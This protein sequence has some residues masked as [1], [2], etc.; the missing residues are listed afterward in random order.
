MV[1]LNKKQKNNRQFL[2]LSRE[3]Y[4]FKKILVID[5]EE[6]LKNRIINDLTKICIKNGNLLFSKT[7]ILELLTNSTSNK[8][9]YTVS[10]N[11]LNICKIKG[12]KTIIKFQ[13]FLEY[14]IVPNIIDTI[15]A[16]NL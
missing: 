7:E 15:K 9:D 6:L 12:H 16:K 4:N 2:E 5:N 14:F 10:E 1:I 11:N 8:I 3:I 13:A